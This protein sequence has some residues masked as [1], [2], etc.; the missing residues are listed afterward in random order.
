M[1]PFFSIIIPTYNRAS[2]IPKAIESVLQQTFVD[3]ELIIIDD[4]SID[5][6]AEIVKTYT[7][8]RI[9]YIWQENQERSVAR[10]KGI[11]IAKGRYI[12][13]LDSDD[14]YLK[15]HLN[16]FYNHINGKEQIAF[17]YSDLLFE[18]ESGEIEKHFHNEEF[19]NDLAFVLRTT[20]HSQQT[21]THRSILE[22]HSFNKRFKVGEDIELWMRIF[23]E[24]P[25]FH[26]KTATVVV[27]QHDN[28]TIDKLNTNAYKSLIGLYDYIFSKPNPG[29][30]IPVSYRRFLYSS[31][32]FGIAKSFILNKKKWNAIY[33]LI[34][35]VCK[36]PFVKYVKYRLYLIYK[37]VFTL[38]YCDIFI[39]EE[40]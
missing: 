2:M 8:S 9:K 36:K 13:F 37:L 32:Y 22:K 20:I 12:C 15:N 40:N 27:V 11:S 38:H 24:F 1:N 29:S 30:K 28:R 3:W 25:V 16:E 17:F 23:N 26:I 33:F 21:C 6:T 10:N 14:Y 34:K 5:N 18:T 4:G 31:V 35:S 7:D 39:K 19:T